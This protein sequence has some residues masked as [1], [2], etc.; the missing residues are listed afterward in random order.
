M[1]KIKR[2]TKNG[3]I[4]DFV[5][6]ISNHA[7]DRMNERGISSESV[8]NAF[9]YGGWNLNE[10]QAFEFEYNGVRVISSKE[11]NGFDVQTTY[12]I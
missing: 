3:N 6:N 9:K 2:K 10:R 5:I 12:Y 4:L 7:Y 8:L 1:T 11:Q